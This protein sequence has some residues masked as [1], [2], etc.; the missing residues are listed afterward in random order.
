M[1][2][3]NP[4]AAWISSALVPTQAEATSEQLFTSA[5]AVG[6][7]ICDLALHDA[8][9]VSWLWLSLLSERRWGLYDGSSGIILFLNYLGF[10]THEECY[11]TLARLAFSS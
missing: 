3:G 2:M 9:R 10:L 4:H 1:A 6:N 7:R 11:T 5:R 8:E